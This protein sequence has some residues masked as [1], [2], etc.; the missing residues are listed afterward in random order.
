MNDK[1]QKFI[2]TL[3]KTSGTRFNA[4]KRLE[5]KDRSSTVCLSLISS[6]MILLTIST[7]FFP[8]LRQ[9]S[10]DFLNLISLFFSILILVL[11]LIQYSGSNMIKSEQFHRCALEIDEIRRDIELKSDCLKLDEL[12]ECKLKY[13]R[14][15][16]KYSLNHDTVDFYEYLVQNRYKYKYIK[17][18]DNLKFV[19]Y[20]FLI[21]NIVNLIIVILFCI[22]VYFQNEI[23]SIF[24]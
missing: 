14:I 16:Q 21:K 12:L 4:S 18:F 11:S 3:R 24:K 17:F 23:I 8:N 7:Y 6:C 2:E 19:I 5:Q 15:L 1:I 10:K 13:D 20:I 9:E 22:L